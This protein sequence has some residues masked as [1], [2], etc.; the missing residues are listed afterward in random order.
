MRSLTA[1]RQAPY[2]CPQVAV[3]PA[4]SEGELADVGRPGSSAPVLCILDLV[5]P[6]A[7]TRPGGPDGRDSRRMSHMRGEPAWAQADALTSPVASVPEL[8]PQ[9]TGMD[10]AGACKPL[11]RRPLRVG[12][13]ERRGAPAQGPGS[14]TQSGA[15]RHHGRAPGAHRGEDLLG[16]DPLQIDRGCAEVGVSELALDDVQRHPLAR[17]LERVR[18][19]QLVRRKPAPHPKALI[20]AS[21]L[22]ASRAS[23]I[24]TSRMSH[25]PY[26]SACM[27]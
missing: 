10:D 13:R 18:V 2:R 24:G 20:S 25:S 21:L 14:Q 23:M 26:R 16:I 22:R 8:E 27:A 3:P 4:L 15:R 7:R 11:G 12:K 1:P 5:S 17:E 6:P 9:A 19:A